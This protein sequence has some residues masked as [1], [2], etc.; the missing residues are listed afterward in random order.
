VKNVL[1]VVGS[2]TKDSTTLK[3]A[4][5]F[6]KGVSEKGHKVTV[7]FLGEKNVQ[8]CKGCT[9]C[10]DNGGNCAIKD[11]M[12]EIYTHYNEC[13]TVVLASP[14]YFWTITAS[15]KAFI[16][17]LFALSKEHKY[18][19]KDSYLLM[20]AGDNNTQTFD[21]PVSYYQQYLTK[22]L[23][24]TEKGMYLAGDCEGGLGK[25]KIDEKHLQTSYELGTQM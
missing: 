14:L 15:T 23:N 2:G 1:V 19:A 9:L 4:N 10:Q 22:A 18:P 11:D 8:G 24:W 20:T 5:S 12:Q 21:Q 25:S 16:D 17:R 7:A 6:A 3:L 13:D